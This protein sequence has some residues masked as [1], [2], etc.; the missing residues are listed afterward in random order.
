MCV[1]AGGLVFEVGTPVIGIRRRWGVAARLWVC[2]Y[3]GGRLNLAWGGFFLILP[4]IPVQSHPSHLRNRFSG[5]W[6]EGGEAACRI[7]KKKE[8]ARKILKIMLFN[9]LPI[10]LCNMVIDHFSSLTFPPSPPPPG[11]KKGESGLPTYLVHLLI[12]SNL[13][14]RHLL[15]PVWG[16]V[17]SRRSDRI[18]S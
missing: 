2:A 8:R 4:C 18:P 11:K 3:W 10:S 16:V 12:I 13:W 1:F 9:Y 17:A 7:W 5:L 15:F 6:G 14:N